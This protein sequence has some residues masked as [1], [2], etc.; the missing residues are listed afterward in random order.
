M[1]GMG[2]L[3]RIAVVPSPN[4]RSRGMLAFGW[5]LAPC[6]LGRSGVT[7]RKREGDGA[8]P[9]GVLRLVFVYYRPDRV[10]RPAATALHGFRPAARADLIRWPGLEVGGLG[11]CQQ[12]VPLGNVRFLEHFN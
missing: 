3:R 5:G 11:P 8:T 6:A 10:R 1:A 7:R 4:G 2:T 12:F 9:A